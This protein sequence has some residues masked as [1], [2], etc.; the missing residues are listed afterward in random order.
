MKKKIIILISAIVA[1]LAAVVIVVCA[2][3]TM[4]K[5]QKWLQKS[6]DSLTYVQTVFEVTDK[7]EKVFIYT[8]TVEIIEGNAEITKATSRLN[9]SFE[10]S[11]IEETNYVE[12]INKDALLN[13]KFSKKYFTFVS[14]FQTYSETIYSSVMGVP[15]YSKGASKNARSASRSAMLSSSEAQGK[16]RVKVVPLGLK[17][18]A[19]V[20]SFSRCMAKKC[21][22][23]FPTFWP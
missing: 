16:T 15:V 4:K 1:V 18:C 21:R 5:C 3:Q 12:N 13:F 9:P 2:T 11:T 23:S 7:Q 19:C 6:A 20:R 8:Q 14:P 17:A 10:F 22:T